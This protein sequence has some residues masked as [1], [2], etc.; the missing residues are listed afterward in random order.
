MIV[1]AMIVE[2][3]TSYS[4][5]LEGQRGSLNFRCYISYAPSHGTFRR[6]F[7]LEAQFQD[8]LMLMGNLDFH[9]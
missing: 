6:N 5:F 3:C 7:K 8:Q 2:L 9:I 4:T 1:I